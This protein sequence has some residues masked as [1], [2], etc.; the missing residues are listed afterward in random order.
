MTKIFANVQNTTIFYDF[1]S[2]GRHTKAPASLNTALE[3][4]RSFVAQLLRHLG[5]SEPSVAE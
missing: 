2:I 1:S 5:R 3:K 4:V